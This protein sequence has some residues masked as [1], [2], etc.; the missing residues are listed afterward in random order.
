MEKE[1]DKKGERK[2]GEERYI[3]VNTGVP[4]GKLTVC[5]VK[6]GDMTIFKLVMF[7]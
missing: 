3:V 7:L 4:G 2:G 1:K 5:H 6:V